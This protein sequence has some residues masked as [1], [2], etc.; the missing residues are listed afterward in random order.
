MVNTNTPPLLIEAD[1][2]IAA[3]TA[4]EARAVDATFCLPGSDQT[5]VDK[6]RACHLP[7]ATLFDIE[8]IADP[9]SPLPHS[10][11][12]ADI[13]TQHMQRLGI[14]GDDWLIVYD[15]SPFLSAA[16]AWWMLCYF[17]HSR[18]SVL[19]GGL[20]A[21]QEAGGAIETGD[22]VSPPTPGDFTAKPSPTGMGVA[23]LKDM[24][25]LVEK[26]ATDRPRQ[27]IDARGRDRFIGEVAEPRPNMKAG[28]MPGAL[29]CPIVSL[30]DADTGKVKSQAAL[31]AAFAESGVDMDKPVVSTCGSGITACGLAFG[32]ALLGKQ[33]VLMYDG[34]WAEWGDAKHNHPI[35]TGE[36]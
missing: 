18:V 26:P 4:G 11:P 36:S 19:N 32:L 24:R 15:A 21:W 31:A 1:A 34:S 33:D 13:F 14:N 9:Q 25:A 12:A 27:I 16:R 5:Q 22:F 28:H 8:A 23:K 3:I 30:L 35:A 10:L 7:Q 2:A 29:S 17:G 20:R 6:F